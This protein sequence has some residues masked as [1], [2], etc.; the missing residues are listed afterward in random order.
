M[1]RTR[2]IVVRHGETAWN[3]EKRWQGHLDSPL[4]AKG[5]S[6]AQALA[7]RLSGE[8][9]SA[10]YTS[11]LGRAYQTAQLIAAATGHSVVLDS[12]LRERKL[13]VFQGLTSEEIRAVHAEEYELYRIRD[14]D[15]AL[16]GGESLRQQVDRNLR[17][18]EEL[19]QRHLGESIVV[20]THGG[21]LSGLFR[22]VLSIPMQAPR[23][24]AFANSSLNI[25]IFQ[26]G[27]WML[28]T[29]G[30]V[31]HLASDDERK[32]EGGA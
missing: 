10:L 28:Q 14:P 19:A 8:R 18:F 16:P 21:V 3:N 6:Q 27:D 11:D 24:F 22:H 23:R 30:D 15:H 12:R 25:F 9:F 13:G 29:W 32:A 2:V 31:S 20:V 7:R 17:C 26:E 5:L 1:Q 4:T